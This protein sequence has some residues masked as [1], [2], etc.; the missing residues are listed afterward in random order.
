MN[1]SPGRS[2]RQATHVKNYWTFPRGIT[3]PQEI[4]DLEEDGKISW[5]EVRLLVAIDAMVNSRGLGCFCTNE[6][7][8]NTI[9]K[10]TQH[11]VD[12][13][14]S[15]VKRGLIIRYFDGGKRYLEAAYSRPLREYLAGLS[16]G[17]EGGPEISGPLRKNPYPGG[18]EKPVAKED[19]K[20]EEELKLSARPTHPA[21]RGSRVGAD[22][23]REGKTTQGKEARQQKVGSSAP[24]AA[25]QPTEARDVVTTT[26]KPGKPTKQSPPIT[27]NEGKPGSNDKFRRPDSKEVVP[28]RLTTEIVPPVTPETQGNMSLNPALEPKQAGPSKH[29]PTDYRWATK[30]RDALAKA[31][32][33]T[34]PVNTL[35]WATQFATMRVLD[36]LNEQE[37]DTVLVWYCGRV[38]KEYI[39]Q[40]YSAK[41]F[42]AKYVPIRDARDRELKKGQAEVVVTPHAQK[43]ADNLKHLHWPKGSLATL[44]EVAQK[45]IDNMVAF[46]ELQAKDDLQHGFA[47][48]RDWLK[49]STSAADRTQEWLRQRFDRV[50]NWDGWSGNT[51]LLVWS[52][53]NEDVRKWGRSQAATYC[54]DAGFWDKYLA[55]LGV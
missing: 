1:G 53:D 52:L 11:T 44:P 2:A 32:K 19:K 3:V 34:K 36:G 6:Y 42:R 23:P 49:P 24:P 25:S 30:L 54:G 17:S 27:T 33:V 43:V 9:R 46:K 13:I 48:F 37:V 50:A 16:S 7:L 41:A 4:M 29:T 55:K 22:G 20:K 14:T 51:K 5:L 35:K 8:A 15:L 38:G 47:G 21:S 39:P 40:A 12:M 28:R 26:S 10:S 31:G 45:C 18:T